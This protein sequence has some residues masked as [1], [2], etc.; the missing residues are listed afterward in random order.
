MKFIIIFYQIF[1]TSKK[2]NIFSINEPFKSRLYE[3]FEPV[4]E[5]KTLLQYIVAILC[6]ITL[7]T[8][9]KGFELERNKYPNMCYFKST[10]IKNLFMVS[11]VVGTTEEV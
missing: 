6:S 9:L 2:D 10:P 1:R 11:I 5:Y 8:S 3:K 7:Q 4:I